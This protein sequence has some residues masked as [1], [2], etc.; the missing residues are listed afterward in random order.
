MVKWM[1]KIRRKR[2]EERQQ[3]EVLEKEERKKIQDRE[4]RLKKDNDMRRDYAER[5]RKEIAEE[6]RKKEFAELEEL[7][8]RR[9]AEESERVV[10]KYYESL[11]ADVQSDIDHMAE[12]ELFDFS[13]LEKLNKQPPEDQ[14]PST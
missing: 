12:D 6:K 4:R 11:P 14:Q 2:E 10:S 9:Q 3:R 8:K 1:E 5:L 13:K 7:D